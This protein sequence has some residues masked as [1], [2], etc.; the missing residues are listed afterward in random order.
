[1]KIVYQD[2]KTELPWNR[3]MVLPGKV[4]K[5]GFNDGEALL[6]YHTFTPGGTV[7]DP[8]FTKYST[9]HLYYDLN[10]GA[11]THSLTEES[12]MLPLLKGRMLAL[13]VDGHHYFLTTTE[14]WTGGT[15]PG[16][17]SYEKLRLT[18]DRKS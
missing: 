6:Y 5:D 18:T 12:F 2:G 8:L 15:P 14:P 10:K 13:G 7:D 17:F 11:K 1:M 16:G 4:I 9:I 3:T